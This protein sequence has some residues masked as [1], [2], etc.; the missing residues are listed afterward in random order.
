MASPFSVI[1]GTAAALFGLVF[2]DLASQA[3]FRNV[4]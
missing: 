4:R 3:A 2:G 1:A